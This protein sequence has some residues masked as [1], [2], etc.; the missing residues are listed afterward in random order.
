MPLDVIY[1]G[2]LLIL[3]AVAAFAISSL[4]G[5]LLA[6]LSAP[7]G[8]LDEPEEE[9]APRRAGLEVLHGAPTERRTPGTLA[10]FDDSLA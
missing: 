5:M 10:R 9:P 2:G 4:V 1:E 6:H 8:L 7:P 3:V